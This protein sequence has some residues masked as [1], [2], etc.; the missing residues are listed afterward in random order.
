[1]TSPAQ[2]S[3]GPAQINPAEVRTRKPRCLRLVEGGNI[4]KVRGT[5]QCQSERLDGSAYCAH[6]LAE[7]VREFK[8]I[9][10][11]IE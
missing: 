8:R 10:G 4:L 7:A 2:A 3:P 6:H 11:E 1:M 5:E 9:T